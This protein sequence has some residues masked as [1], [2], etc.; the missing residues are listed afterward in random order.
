MSVF[1]CVCGRLDS[2]LNIYS[3]TNKSFSFCASLSSGMDV[4]HPNWVIMLRVLHGGWISYET[5][6]VNPWYTVKRTYQ[7]IWSRAGQDL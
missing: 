3:C 7:P 6:D 1:V 4:R 5:L 2:L